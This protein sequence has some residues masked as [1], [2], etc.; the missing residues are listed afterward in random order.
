VGV[1]GS[2]GCRSSHA[3]PELN[4]RWRLYSS[5]TYLSIDSLFAPSAN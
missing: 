2:E 3:F 1:V 5:L 4:L